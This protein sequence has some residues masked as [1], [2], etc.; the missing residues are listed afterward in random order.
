MWKHIRVTVR[1]KATLMIHIYWLM[2][3]EGNGASSPQYYK[4]AVG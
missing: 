1:E 4:E 3:F 2:P